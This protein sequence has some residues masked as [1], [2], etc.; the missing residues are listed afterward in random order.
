VRIAIQQPNYIPWIGFF[1]KMARADRFVLLDNV[2]YPMRSIVNRN[3]IKASNGVI[4][5]TVPVEVKGLQEIKD[6]KISGNKWRKKHLLSLMHAYGRS[7]YFDEYISSFKTLYEQDIEN[8]FE[9]NIRIIMLMKDLLGIKTELIRASELEGISSA[10][11]NER[12]LSICQQLDGTSFILGEGSSR[13]YID[14]ELFKENQILIEDKSFIH[15]IYPQCWGEFIS[16]LSAIDLLFN[17]G[18]K[19]LEVILS[20]SQ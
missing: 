17:C 8:L 10:S 18:E 1:E 4:L 2:Q 12:I 7:R 5:L 13:Q 20:A 6:I 19:S 15:P 14:R 16:H 11:K 9:W 3:K